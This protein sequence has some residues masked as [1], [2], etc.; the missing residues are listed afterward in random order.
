ME[1]G[2]EGGRE[3]FYFKFLQR[4]SLDG[5]YRDMC[6]NIL[7]FYSNP[8]LIQILQQC[9]NTPHLEHIQVIIYVHSPWSE[10]KIWPY[11]KT[12]NTEL[13]SV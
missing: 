4:E 9:T 2:R 3:G 5:E 1:G 6:S 8:L 12:S 7:Q 10:R 13:H 11:L